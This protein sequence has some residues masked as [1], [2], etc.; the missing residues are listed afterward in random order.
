M[1]HSEI[2]KPFSQTERER[3]ISKLIAKTTILLSIK[4][5]EQPN[6]QQKLS[7]QNLACNN[8][9]NI[10]QTV[11]NASLNWSTIRNRSSETSEEET[12]E[13]NEK[14][15]FK[16]K[17]QGNL[18]QNF[19]KQSLACENNNNIKQTVLN[20]SRHWSTSR[21]RSSETSQ[22]RASETNEKDAFQNDLTSLKKSKIWKRTLKK[23]S[24]SYKKI[25]TFISNIKRK[26]QNL[27]KLQQRFKKRIKRK[28]GL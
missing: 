25:T 28:R 20:S 12:S 18:Q 15:A 22:E 14:E 11:L 19:S 27:K 24:I 7:E 9:T 8:N 3:D 16:K 13:T 1:K 2:N 4:K 23:Q 17:E 21:N 26:H 6:L 10:K 5:K